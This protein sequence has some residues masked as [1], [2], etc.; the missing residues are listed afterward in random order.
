MAREKKKRQLA[1]NKRLERQRRAVFTRF[2]LLFTLLATFGLVA[3]L[4]GFEGVIN[5]IPFFTNN[6]YV[7]LVTG[8]V[9]LAFT[10]TL[11]KKLGD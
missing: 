8:V 5:Q 11:Y 3:T 7:L 1:I 4:Y 6:P 9:I 2:P 10:G